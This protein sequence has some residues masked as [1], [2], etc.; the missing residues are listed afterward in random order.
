MTLTLTA[1][2][3]GLNRRAFHRAVGAEYATVARFGPQQCFALHALVEVLAG[4]RW[5]DLGSGVVTVRTG[6]D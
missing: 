2:P 1:C 6:Q 4:I 5:H 3:F